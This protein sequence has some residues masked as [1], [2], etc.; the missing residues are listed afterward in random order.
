MRRRRRALLLLLMGVSGGWVGGWVLL[1][2]LL[3]LLQRVNLNPLLL[4]LPFVVRRL[5]QSHLDH[6]LPYI[7]S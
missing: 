7:N 2:L 3:L 4:L 5:L 6:E 1:L